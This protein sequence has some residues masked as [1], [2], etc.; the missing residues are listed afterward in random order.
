MSLRP[1]KFTRVL[2]IGI[3]LSIY[4][5]N[6]LIVVNAAQT[7]N[8]PD[9]QLIVGVRTISHPVAN[10]C[11]SF[12]DQLEKELQ[13]TEQEN[14]Q[15]ITEPILNQYKGKNYSRYFGLLNR[16]KDGSGRENYIDIE[17]GPNSRS[18]GDLTNPKNN[19]KFKDSI[20]FLP[21]TDTGLFLKTGIKLLLK[22][23]EAINL[24][25]SQNLEDLLSKLKKLNIGVLERTSTLAEFEKK[26]DIYPNLVPIESIENPDNRKLGINALERALSALDNQGQL[27]DDTKIDALASDVLIVESLL[28]HGV[29]QSDSKIKEGEIAYLKGRDSYK[30]E[31]FAVFPSNNYESPNYEEEKYLPKLNTEEYVIAIKKGSVNEEIL[32]QLISN[33][34]NNLS[35]AISKLKQAQDNTDNTI[36]R[37]GTK[38]EPDT[39]TDDDPDNT[40]LNN[41]R[42]WGFLQGVLV[43]LIPAIAT[44]WVAH[45][46]NRRNRNDTEHN[47]Q[48][49]PQHKRLKGTVFDEITNK[50]ISNAQVSLEG[51]TLLPMKTTDNFGNFSFDFSNSGEQIT[52]Y[53]TA[54]NYKL[55]KIYTDPPSDDVFTIQIRLS[56][57]SHNQ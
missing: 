4:L 16:S 24:R 44:I 33:T 21:S 17:C 12:I 2:F 53:V 48:S 31:G 55:Y 45:I 26:A 42:L 10:F 54:N 39:V 47:P 49:Q 50:R 6:L 41:D 9:N 38:N 52:L 13:E 46:N 18:S 23:D 3:I 27:D 40:Q 36:T 29:E 37:G 35:D 34:F 43:T 1:I 15:V 8:L 30:S 32:T 25:N 11:Y 56:P 22:E 19:T 20:T 51:R 5:N 28:E 57:E 14:I 7:L